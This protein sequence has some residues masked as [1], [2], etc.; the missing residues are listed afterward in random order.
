MSPCPAPSPAGRFRLRRR[1]AAL[2]SAAILA[3]GG[4]VT[5]PAV[6]VASADTPAGT[7]VPGAGTG[8]AAFLTLSESDQIFATSAPAHAR[9]HVVAAN[10]SIPTG[11][12]VF[13]SDG[14]MFGSTKVES[15]GR[16]VVA[17]PSRL[18]WLYWGYHHITATYQPAT[19]AYRTSSGVAPFTVIR[20]LPSITVTLPRTAVHGSLVRV[21]VVVRYSGGVIGTGRISLV[22]GG[23]TLA[24][25][26][27]HTDAAELTSRP[28][29]SPA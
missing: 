20:A 3:V 16:A 22:E 10:G 24:Q 13:R 2:V 29:Y 9:V 23:R 11:I 8:T 27:V 26:L 12:V 4:M 6:A 14:V 1:P 25:G 5:P 19:T 18:P 21:R 7:S 28:G 17:V 15:N